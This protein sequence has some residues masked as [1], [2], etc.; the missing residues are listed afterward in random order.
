ME[1]STLGRAKAESNQPYKQWVH[2][3][4]IIIFPKYLS[5][6]DRNTSI[7]VHRLNTYPLVHQGFIHMFL[8]VLA[9]TPLLERFEA[10]HGTLTSLALFFGPLSTLPGGLYI[11]FERYVFRGDVAILGSSIWIFLLLGSEAMKTYKSNPH[12]SLGTYQIPTWTTPLIAIVFVYALVANTSF[13]GHLC[14]VSVGYVLGLGYLKILFPPEKILRWFEGKLNLLG[15]LPH[16]VSVDQKTYGRYGILPTGGSAG[17]Q[18]VAMGYF[19]STQRLANLTL[20]LRRD[21]RPLSHLPPYISSFLVL[22]GVAWLL[23]L[24][25]N[26]YSRQT[27]IS[28]NALLPGQVHT[29]F[30]GSEQNIFRG[31]RQE[32]EAVKDAEYDVVSQK[33]QSILRESGL[34]VATQN[35]EYRSAGNIHSGQNVYGIIQAPRGDGTEAIVLV[36]AW[37]TIKGEPNLHGV[38]LA[39]TLARYFKRWSLWSKDIIFLITPDSK[40]GAQAWIDAY[41]DMHPSSVDPLPLKSGALQGAIVFEYPFD[42]RFESIH[43]VYDGVNGQLPNLDLINTAVSIS[44]GQMGIKAELQEMWGHDDR[45]KMRLQTMLKGMMRQGLGSAA[46]LHSSFIP[47]HIDAI[48][49][50]TV[51]NGWQDEM[52]LGRTVESL[53]RSLN[54]LLEH[55]HQSF[56]FYLLMQTNR[57]VSIGT[58]LP[59]AMLIA[60]NFTVMAIALWMKSGY[61]PDEIKHDTRTELSPKK[62][63]TVKDSDSE[64]IASNGTTLER[65]LTLPVALVTGLHFLGVVPLY[66]FNHLPQQLLAPTAYYFAL[67]NILIPVILALLLER[68]RRP[69]IQE[70][71]LIK[72]FSLLLLGLFLSALATLNFSLSLL[73]GLF[74]I[75]L[76]L[77]G[78]I[79]HQGSNSAKQGNANKTLMRGESHVLVK[80]ITGVAILNL[81]APTAVLLGASAIAKVSVEMIL[82]EAAFGWDVWGMWTQVAVWCVWWPAWLIG[83]VGTISS[84]LD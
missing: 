35:Y 34:K 44:G 5:S 67:I 64:S 65:H 53:V 13:L 7:I 33:F 45:Y 4:I 21:P 76:S 50:Q 61:S 9:L 2:V 10:E 8:N 75:P 52:A 36:A 1:R 31:Y 29:Y 16:Y 82:T 22:I 69:T 60:G 72:S 48:T 46:G 43:I 47:Y 56:F 58:Y 71:L 70:F 41:H 17:N 25:L 28:E 79:E 62:G 55:L 80:V 39:L 81:V 14:G 59:S 23:L 51:G 20:K 26:E 3:M 18:G 38:T 27:Y 77:I 19:G 30:S 84:V 54:N 49:L 83:T 63:K 68:F 32:I 57:F 24:P 37:K 74:C 15:I 6:P 11:L 40:S 78:Y 12:F 66:I 73:L 42:H